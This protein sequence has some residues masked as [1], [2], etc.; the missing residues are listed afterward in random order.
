[1]KQIAFVLGLGLV[2]GACSV[3]GDDGTGGGVEGGVDDRDDTLGIVC[4][5][6]FKLAGSFTAG[7]PA[8]PADSPTGCWPVGTWTFSATLDTNEC[9]TAPALAASYAFRVDRTWVE[10]SD[11]E[12]WVESYTY[13]GDQTMLFSLGVSEGG[14]ADCEGGLELYSAD[15]TEYWNFKPMQGDTTIDGFGEY[16]KYETS[17]KD[18]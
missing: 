7:T 16:A 1:M 14:S 18:E 4:N 17:Q 11:S 13:M 15:G 6:T 3:G 9:A 12:G 10:S 8:R 2:V 5:A